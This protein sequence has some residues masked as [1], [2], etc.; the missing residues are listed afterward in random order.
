MYEMNDLQTK[1]E[2]V[3]E[4]KGVKVFQLPA[5]EFD[6]AARRRKGDRWS[7]TLGERSKGLAAIRSYSLRNPG[8]P[9][10]VQH[11]QTGEMKMLRRRLNDQ[12][13][14]HNRRK[15]A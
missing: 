11:E 6:V 3:S 9:V 4:Y 12:R 5:E 13:L 15:H 1:G 14:K 7:S 10:I 8:K 2:I